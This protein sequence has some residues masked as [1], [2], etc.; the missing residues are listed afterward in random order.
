M[1]DGSG[2]SVRIYTIGH[3]SRSFEEF[4]DLLHA[5]SIETVADIRR[6]PGSRKFPHFDRENLAA[7]LPLNSVQYVWMQALGGLRHSSKRFQSPNTGL[8]NPGFRGYADYMATLE[9]RGAVDD[10]LRLARTSL[11]ACMCAEALYW[12]CHRRL[13][14]DYLVANHLEVFHILSRTNA[15]P[16][17]M[18]DSARITRE[19]QVT[20]PPVPD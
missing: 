13:L 9:F 20:Y 6:L 8:E 3:S 4:L 12:R 19:G 11:T 16:H 10:L 17:R 15:S 18:T 7:V 1:N 2:G 14:S 5:F